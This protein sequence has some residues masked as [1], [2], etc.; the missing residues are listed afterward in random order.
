MKNAASSAIIYPEE[1]LKA[2]FAQVTS[3]FFF[4]LSTW[5]FHR[6]VT[7]YREH[8]RTT[9]KY[10]SH[11]WIYEVKPL[12]F[13]YG[14]QSFIRL[15]LNLLFCKFKPGL[16]FPMGLLLEDKELTFFVNETIKIENL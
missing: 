14:L 6:I 8:R 7:V 11:E 15:P 12:L 3:Q 13:I 2:V 1:N 10:V 16:I 9:H 4:A 5:E